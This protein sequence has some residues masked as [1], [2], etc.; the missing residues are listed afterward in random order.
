[1]APLLRSKTNK[2][3]PIRNIFRGH[4]IALGQ[5]YYVENTLSIKVC[6]YITEFI[7]PKYNSNTELANV[8]GVDEKTIRLILK[9]DFNLSLD[10][11]KKICDSQNIKPSE[12]LNYIGE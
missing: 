11:F 9:G 6:A 12:V 7:R 4:F 1:M 5:I 3:C 8:A 10:L 2:K